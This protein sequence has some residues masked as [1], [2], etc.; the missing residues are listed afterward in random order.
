MIASVIAQTLGLREVHGQPLLET[1]KRH[2]Q[3]VPRA[4]M[5][6]VLDSFE[7]LI[8]LLEG[9]QGRQAA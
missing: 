3:E 5:L 1:L 8:T 2:L 6:L 7:H 4:P 9:D